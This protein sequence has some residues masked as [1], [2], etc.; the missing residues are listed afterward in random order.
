MAEQAGP[1]VP[2]RA[3]TGAVFMSIKSIQ[4]RFLLVCLLGAALMLGACKIKTEI[5]RE[6]EAQGLLV[7]GDY[8]YGTKI[9]AYGAPYGS[10]STAI[11]ALGE[12]L[13]LWADTVSGVDNFK[14]LVVDDGGVT[15]ILLDYTG[16]ITSDKAV[17]FSAGSE[18]Y[19]KGTLVINMTRHLSEETEILNQSDFKMSVAHELAH[20]FDYKG[21][22][23]ASAEFEASGA[24]E[25]SEYSWDVINENFAETT[26]A[27]WHGVCCGLAACL[28]RLAQPA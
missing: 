18:R 6:A 2:V 9:V 19:P 15:T 8:V 12:T 23:D 11:R 14:R 10:P 5:D 26:A 28:Y 27:L 13:V 24:A 17:F 1:P 20:A 21:G 16:T 4:F 22:S 25:Q 7:D 3:A